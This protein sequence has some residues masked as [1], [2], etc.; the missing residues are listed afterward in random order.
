[1]PF[2]IKG[3]DNTGISPWLL[4]RTVAI[5][6]TRLL[7][8]ETSLTLQQYN[9]FIFVF[10]NPILHRRPFQMVCYGVYFPFEFFRTWR[11]ML[12]SPGNSIPHIL[13]ICSLLPALEVK[14]DLLNFPPASLIFPSKKGLQM[15]T[16]GVFL[17]AVQA[18]LCPYDPTVEPHWMQPT[19]T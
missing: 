1:M 16:S 11:W 4:Y 3:D 17:P 12:P 18:G 5:C 7:L 6:E 2:Q 15:T 8:T 19:H 14:S 10:T 13:F 9:I